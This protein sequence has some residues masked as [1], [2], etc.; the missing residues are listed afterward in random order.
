MIE[1]TDLTV[2]YGEFTAV[3]GLTL[4]IPKGAKFG[5]LGPN[6]AGKTSTIHCIAGLLAPTR[7]TIC[8]D[9]VNVCKEPH[10]I[11]KLVG[12]VPQTLALYPAL[13]VFENLNIFGALMGLR[14]KKRRQRV[15]WGLELSQ[16]TAR[17]ETKV[18]ELSGGMKRR[19]NL[20]CSL[21]HEPKV[22]ICDEPTTGVDPQSRNHIFETIRSLQ[23]AGST[24]VYTT[25]YM[26]EVEALC[27]QV[28]IV[29]HGK[30]IAHDTLE[31][32][33]AGGHRSSY[34][35]ELSHDVTQE[36]LE[37]ALQAA[38]IDT[39]SLNATPRTLEEVFLERTGRQLRE[40]A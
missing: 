4:K 9:G 38:S 11:R 21:L 2:K 36:A 40:E 3:E 19:L 27:D 33:L 37:A 12:H 7:G 26:E 29:D 28:A 23:E 18:K 34:K 16:L 1:I 25:H 13:S 5:M 24:V 22:I 30:I 14:G 15:E 32:L 10:T 31:A 20:A 6:G 35:V 8:V 39:V 17:K